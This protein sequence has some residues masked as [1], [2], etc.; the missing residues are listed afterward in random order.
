MKKIL[1]LIF[2]ACILATFSH[3][4]AET[5]INIPKDLSTASQECVGC[6]K[7]TSVN[8]YQEWGRSKHFR[9]NVGCY[10][11]HEAQKGDPDAIEHEGVF[12]SIIVSPKDCS[13]CH[14]KEVD[15]FINSHHSKAG[16]IMGSLDNTLAEVVEGNRG[17]KTEGFPD[18]VSAAAVNG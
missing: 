14:E 16:R 9:A 7:E 4:L 12:V 6:H 3:A 18:G 10:E 5:T 11:C 8:I 2:I 17:M 13:R 1:Y 15:E